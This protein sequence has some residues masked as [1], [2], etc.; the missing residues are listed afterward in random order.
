M[1]RFQIFNEE[2]I[3]SLRK[4]GRILHDCLEHVAAL[5][6]PGV[7]TGFLDSMAETFIR[8]HGGI[9]GFK[10]YQG[11]PATLCTSVN[12]VCVH[13]IPGLQELKEGDIISI[14]CGVILDGLNTDACI[15]VPV[16]VISPQA[17]SLMET[18][19]E[20]L[21][22]AI[23]VVKAG[24]HVGDISATVER[25]ARSRGFAPIR[26]LTGHGLGT[27]L[28]QYPDIPNVGTAKTG[29]VLPAMTLIAIEPIISA[30]S[31]AIAEGD[32]GWAIYAKDHALIAH[33][34]HTLLVRDGGNEVLTAG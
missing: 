2:E 1:P 30:G 20:A 24:T 10:G 18:S 16:G 14:D 32:D 21:K 19:A 31:D 7:T 26:A 33:F 22:Q 34:E 29:P 12:D 13:G 9:L 27:T 8:D 23:A 3:A 4:G 5:V 6:E 17:Q 15:T 28:H 11:F 25:V